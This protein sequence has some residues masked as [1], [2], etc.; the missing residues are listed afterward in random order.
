MENSVKKLFLVV[1]AFNNAVQENTKIAKEKEHDPKAEVRNR[2]L[3]VFPAEHPKVKD[4]QLPPAQGW[5]LV[6]NSFKSLHSA[7]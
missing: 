6:T 5:W 1:D 4:G 2:G 3:C 7:N